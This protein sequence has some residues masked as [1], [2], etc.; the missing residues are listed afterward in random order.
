MSER[1][2]HE[3]VI[4]H[5]GHK[6]IRLKT[7][8]LVGF[9]PM[10]EAAERARTDLSRAASRAFKL[11]VAN[12]DPAMMEYD[13][14]RLEWFVQ[15]VDDWS[16]SMRGAIEKRRGVKTQEERIALLRNTTGRTPAEAAAFER[17][18][19]MLEARMNGV[20]YEGFDDGEQYHACDMPPA[21]RTEGTR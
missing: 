1:T 9:W 13:L 15:G 8:R 2:L 17:K 10:F 14:E 21:T 7:G 20:P 6:Y 5:R 16:Q 4:D 12:E 11:A 19:N 18:A 3:R